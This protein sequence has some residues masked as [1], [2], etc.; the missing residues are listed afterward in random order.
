MNGK[1][2][3]IIEA[4]KH[5]QEH[6]PHVPAARPVQ[7]RRRLRR[8]IRPRITL[9][10]RIPASPNDHRNN[11]QH[12][13][14]H[15]RPHAP[16]QAL[17]IQPIAKDIGSDNLARPIED[18]IERPSPDVELRVIE[19]VK[20]VRGE[21]VA[22]QEHWKEADDPDIGLQHF[23]EAEEFAFPGGVFHEDDVGAV[24]ADDGLGVD[25]RPGEAGAH[26]GED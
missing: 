9:L 16:P 13:P 14:N 8:R 4:I 3:T 26:E 11:Q 10:P 12:A 7:F 21:P 2:L 22:R 6:R 23:D 19:T 5:I 17:D 25:E 20:L 1:G 24:G 18:A 15:P